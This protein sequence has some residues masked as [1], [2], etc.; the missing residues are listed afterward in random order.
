[1]IIKF[2]TAFVGKRNSPA[3]VCVL[4]AAGGVGTIAVQIA[5]VEKAHVTATCATDAVELVKSLGVDRVIDY[6]VDD[7]EDELHE[8]FFDIILDCAGLGPKYALEMPWKYRK[9]VTLEPPILSDTDASGLFFGTIRSIA[10]LVEENIRSLWYKRGIIQWGIFR[11]SR[12][13]IEYLKK[14]ADANRI[15]PVVDTIFEFESADKAIR[16][17]AEGHLRGKIVLNLFHDFT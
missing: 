1:M 12:K 15:R 9:Y 2:S 16:K 7:V 8:E 17:L 10:S 14:Q 6:A 13:G 5:K 3:K 11:P 4:G